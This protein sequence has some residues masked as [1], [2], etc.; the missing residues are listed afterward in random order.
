MRH[1]IAA[2]DLNVNDMKNNNEDENWVDK[3][4]SC[5]HC[6]IR[7][8]DADTLHCRYRDGCHYKSIRQRNNELWKVSEQHEN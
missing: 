5:I 2:I 8:D 4:M 6:Y 7:K 1:R 3:C